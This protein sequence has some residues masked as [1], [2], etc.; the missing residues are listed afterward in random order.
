MTDSNIFIIKSKTIRYL[1]LIALFFSFS[2]G[3]IKAQSSSIKYS[4]DI[5]TDRSFYVVEDIV[6]F[7]ISVY[8][9]D[10]TIEPRAY[11]V[12]CDLIG[13]NGVIQNSIKL[14][15][16]DG[17]GDSEISIPKHLKSGY[18]ILRAY[19]REMRSN[20]ADYSYVSL[21]IVN[22]IEPDII[23]SQDEF[24]LKMQL[25]SN[26]IDDVDYIKINNIKDTYKKRTSANCNIQFDISKFILP[27][28]CISIVPKKS[29]S[30]NKLNISKVSNYKVDKGLAYDE[31]EGITLSGS[32]VNKNN[33]NSIIGKRVFVSIVG[34]K[35]VYTSITDSIGNF[36]VNLPNIND[37]H[38]MYISTDTIDKDAIILIHKDNDLRTDFWLDKEFKISKSE[39][40]LA[41]LISQGVAIQKNFGANH[42]ED[43]QKLDFESFYDSPNETTV[44]MDFIDLPNLH[45]YFT[46]LPSSVRLYKRGGDYQ[47]RIL[48]KNGIQ[49]LLNPLIM[50]DYVAVNDLKSVLDINPKSINRI[51]VVNEYYQKGDISFGGII[52]FI[53]NNND[54]GGLEFKNS[55]L[56]INYSFLENKNKSQ[57][58]SLEGIPDSRTT[59]FFSSIP[60]FENGNANIQFQTSDMLGEFEVIVQGIDNNGKRFVVKKGFKVE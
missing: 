9:N 52:N 27:T 17:I 3:I 29:N 25:D 1:L 8:N 6:K 18:Y 43:N 22:I 36:Y 51:E 55:S 42:R 37:E 13:Q 26:I 30:Y 4:I 34:T 33:S 46:E 11:Y 54:F 47:A 41:L 15:T 49:L 58:I 19:T 60:K 20:P 40:K 5:S 56:V 31:K 16:I 50:V 12:Y 59:L 10:N 57:K 28:V 23:G 35:N 7:H 38:E 24:S 32:L 21:K 14:Q 44:I 53:S 48:D 39:K 2:N 45:M